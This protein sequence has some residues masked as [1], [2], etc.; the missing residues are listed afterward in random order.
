MTDFLLQTNKLKAWNDLQK[1]LDARKYKSNPFEQKYVDLTTSSCV[2]DD[3]TAKDDFGLEFLS[4]SIRARTDIISCQVSHLV[5]EM[6]D[7]S[8]NFSEAKE[9]EEDHPKKKKIKDCLEVDDY[10]NLFIFKKAASHSRHDTQSQS[11]D[12]DAPRDNAELLWVK[13]LGRSLE[14][15]TI[16]DI[17][18]SFCDSRQE[19][20]CPIGSTISSNS[21]Q[22]GLNYADYC[23]TDG[24]ISVM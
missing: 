12:F 8:E 19:F 24:L 11:T 10:S 13:E 7:V 14:P 15:S 20:V 6:M 17:S 3:L 22:Q 4:K 21:V 23:S 1:D 5:K 9:I 16:E 2:V 18:R